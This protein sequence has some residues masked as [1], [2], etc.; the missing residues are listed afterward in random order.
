MSNELK[1]ENYSETQELGTDV[2]LERLVKLYVNHRYVYAERDGAASCRMCGED[3]GVSWL[4]RT[5]CRCVLPGAPARVFNVLTSVCRF[6]TVLF[7]Y[8]YF[9]PFFFSSPY[10]SQISVFS[11]TLTPQNIVLQ[12]IRPLL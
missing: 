12:V 2:D 7:L 4:L 8:F 11:P 6:A 5:H 1:F 9:P 3:G 10:S